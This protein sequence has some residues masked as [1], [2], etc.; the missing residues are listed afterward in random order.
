MSARLTPQDRLLRQ[1]TERQW[2]SKVEHILSMHG[3]LY[4]H[5][6]DNIP[7]NGYIQ[8][9]RAGFPDLVAVRGSRVLYVELKKETGKLSPA[10]EEWLDAL[11][12][13]GQTVGHEV[14]VWRP[15]DIE[16]VISTV[17]ENWADA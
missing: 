11:R 7:R 1:I 14:Y 9:I 4:Y 17:K 5:A 10:Q 3:W 16:Q 12:A 6:P 13:A 2:Q 15:S 8:N